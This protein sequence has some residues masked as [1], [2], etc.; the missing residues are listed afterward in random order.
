MRDLF[1]LMASY[2]EWMNTKLYATANELSIEALHADKGAF[3]GCLF[4][5]LNHIVVADRIWLQRFAEHPS[6]PGAL[7]WVLQLPKPKSLDQRLFTDF[8]EMAEHRGKLDTTI[9]AWVG[10]LSDA[11]LNHV[12]PY[13]SSKGVVRKRLSSLV[14]HFFNHQTHH[15]GQATTL[16]SQFGKDIGVTDLLALI[17]NE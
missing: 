12:L 1:I 7:A 6:G 10:S 13:A 3:F 2:N 16:L 17:P 5:T 11:D 15:R 14:Q 8:S 9:K 4:G